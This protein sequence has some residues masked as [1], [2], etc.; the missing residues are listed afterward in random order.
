M[1]TAELIHRT[2]HYDRTAALT[3]MPYAAWCA[4]A[5]ALNASIARQ[6]PG[7]EAVL[8]PA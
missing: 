1:S 6:N 7:T 8:R 4:F 2:A 3:L 5:T